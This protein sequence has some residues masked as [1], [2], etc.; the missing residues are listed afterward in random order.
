MNRTMKIWIIA[1]LCA[2]VVG[3]CAQESGE[4]TEKTDHNKEEHEILCGVLKAAVGKWGTSGEGLSDPLKKA[5]GRTIFGSESGGTLEALKDLP[6]DYTERGAIRGNFCGQPYEEPKFYS[7]PHRWSGFSAPHNLVCLCTKGENGWPV[8]SSDNQ[9]TLCGKTRDALGGGNKGWTGNNTGQAQMKATWKN[10]VTECLEG[11]RQKS[12]NLEEALNNF[13][14]K[15]Q[16]KPDG[17]TNPSRYIL[18]EN[19]VTEKDYDA[20][21]GY[22]KRGVCVAYFNA[23]YPM[24]WWTDLQNALPEEEKFQEEKKKREEEERRKQKEREQRTDEPQAESLK[25]G[26]QTNNQTEKSQKDSLHEAIRKYNTTSSTP[27]STPSSWLLRAI[28]L[29]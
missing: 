18:G 6:G 28:L 21:T 24:P 2:S 20:C 8:N 12:G 17:E 11:G 25:S 9:D 22:P 19:N 4:P 15:L 13:L 1:I 3:V 26:T 23:T 16:H 10:V 5:L 14:N 7:A 27:I 29:I